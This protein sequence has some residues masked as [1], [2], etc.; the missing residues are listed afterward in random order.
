M[1]SILT[2]YQGNLMLSQIGDNT[3]TFYIALFTASPTDL[4]S[5][6]NEVAGGSYARQQTKFTVASGKTTGN[7][8]PLSFTNM[9]SATVHYVGVCRTLSGTSND[10]LTYAALNSPTG[11]VVASGQTLKFEISD[12][13]ITL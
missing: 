4:G 6:T 10:L 3:T 11:I 2:N 1:A 13:A 12:I 7:V 9:P 8:S 5:F